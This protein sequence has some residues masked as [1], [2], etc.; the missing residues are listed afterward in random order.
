M[1]MKS[2]KASTGDTAMILPSFF[3]RMLPL[4]EYPQ[5]FKPTEEQ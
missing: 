3:L 1:A 5:I 4:N 2:I